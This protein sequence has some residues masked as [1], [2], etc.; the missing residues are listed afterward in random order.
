MV[1]Q[2]YEDA[3]QSEPFTLLSATAPHTKWTLGSNLCFVYPTVAHEGGKLIVL[4]VLD[5][6]VKG[7]AGQAIQCA[8]AMYRLP[9]KLG[10]PTE[11][12]YP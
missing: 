9:E 4:S 3:Y 10:L 11:G 5:N 8:N 6:L 7:A 2:V 12:V 1:Q